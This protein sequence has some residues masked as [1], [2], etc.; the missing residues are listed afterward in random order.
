MKSIRTYILLFALALAFTAAAQQ[1]LYIVNGVATEDISSIPPSDIL[2]TEML[3]ADEETIA[4][5]GAKASNGV[6]LITLR[7]DK[8]AVF[9]DGESFNNYI[10]KQ[11]KWAADEPAARVILRYTITSEGHT[12]IGTELESTDS[13]LKRRVLKAVAEAPLWHPAMKDGAPV[14][15]EGVLRVQLPE[16]KPM[17]RQ[18]EVVWR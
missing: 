12:V 14:D 8:P 3:P 9:G 15:S 6:T 18:I 5:Y 4:R 13:R 17:P 7:Y 10:S 1:P 2:E 11:V 16:G